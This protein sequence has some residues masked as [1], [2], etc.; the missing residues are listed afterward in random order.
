[1][2]HPYASAAYAQSLRHLGEPLAVPEWEGQVL[3]RPTPRGGRRDAMGPYPLAVIAPGADLAAGLNRL[4][5]A[6]LVS[7]VAVLDDRQRPSMEP[8]SAAFDFVRPFK[9]HF[10]HDRSL[11]PLELGKHHRY[12]VRR[13]LTRVDVA[14]IRLGDHQSAW[15]ALYDELVQRRGLADAHAFPAAHHRTL[16]GL[17]GLRAFGAFI[18]GR[19]VSAHL[20]VTHDGYAMSHL[21][22]SSAEGY[23][24]GAAYAV[25]HFAVGALDDCAAINFGGG[26]GLSTDPADGLVRFKKGF[27]NCTATAWL[28]GK[29]LDPDAYRSLGA[30]HDDEAFFP[31]Y[32]GA[33]VREPANAH[34]G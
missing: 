7:V 6:G 28:A 2:T 33:T 12:E 24:S 30:G 22:A 31:A 11:G 9:S 14:E 26:A 29:V 20:F 1:M 5:D 16:A 3:T 10:L 32:R 25:N 19:L 34:Q 18:D 21:A 4:S 8:L 23:A 13:A 15:Q 17:P 27:A